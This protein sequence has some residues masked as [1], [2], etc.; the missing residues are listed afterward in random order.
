MKIKLS[1]AQASGVLP[2]REQI[3]DAPGSDWL[4]A[5]H[6]F[7]VPIDFSGHS[8]RTIQHATH[9]AALTG[10]SIHLLHVFQM[11]EYP[12]AFYQGL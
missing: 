7:L 9:L 8:K 12:A 5:Y 4:T 3:L 1:S 10:A 2:S 11:L 6:L